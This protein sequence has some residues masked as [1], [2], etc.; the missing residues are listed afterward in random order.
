VNGFATQSKLEQ[1]KE[2]VGEGVLKLVIDSCWDM[3][4]VTD[5]SDHQLDEPG[6][7]NM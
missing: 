5:V 3:E 6:T 4:G 2:L 7:L 1:V